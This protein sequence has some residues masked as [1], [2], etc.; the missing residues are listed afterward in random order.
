MAHLLQVHPCRGGWLLFEPA[1]PCLAYTG[2]SY[3]HT[4]PNQLFPGSKSGQGHRR[5]S[6][7]GGNPACFLHLNIKSSPRWPVVCLLATNK[8][9]V[10]QEP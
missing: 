8:P 9:A 10:P 1:W 3:L 5:L 2:P 4:A 7:L 6:P